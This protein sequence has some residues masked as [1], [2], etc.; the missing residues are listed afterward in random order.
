[1]STSSSSSHRFD[2][3][4]RKFSFLAEGEK[5]K[6]GNFFFWKISPLKEFSPTTSST[7]CFVFLDFGS[8]NQHL[9]NIAEETFSKHEEFIGHIKKRTSSSH[10]YKQARVHT[11]TRIRSIHTF[12]KPV[13]VLYIYIGIRRG[14]L[15]LRTSR[16]CGLLEQW[17]T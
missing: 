8:G 7:N 3:K 4:L 12:A 1:M 2:E 6:F 11:H 9:D 5:N 14:D 16:F 15:R 13:T 17:V 10:S